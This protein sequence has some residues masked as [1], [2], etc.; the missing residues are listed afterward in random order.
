[1]SFGLD[2]VV[3]TIRERGDFSSRLCLAPGDI[4]GEDDWIGRLLALWRSNRPGSRLPSRANFDSVDLMAMARGR[5]HIVDTTA[6]Q[7][8]GYFF[9]LWGSTVTLDRGQNYTKTRL[10]EMPHTTMRDAAIEDYGDVVATGVPAYQLVYHVQDFIHYSYARLLLPLATDGRRVDQVLVAVNQ[11]DV[12]ELVPER[13]PGPAHL[14]LV[15][16]AKAG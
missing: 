8:A 6:D 7:P 10:G 5:V 16:S 3:A 12:P 13:R 1:M 11:R 14:R 9:R 4:R 2:D 15:V